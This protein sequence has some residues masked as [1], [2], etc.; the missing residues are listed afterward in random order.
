MFAEHVE[1]D[2]ARTKEK[3]KWCKV[4]KHFN[5]LLKNETTLGFRNFLCYVGAKTKK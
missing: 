3:I 4:A 5:V 2:N 1:P